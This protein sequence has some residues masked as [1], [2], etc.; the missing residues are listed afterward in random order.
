ML[1]INISYCVSL[2]GCGSS[3]VGT[4]LQNLGKFVYPTLPVSFGIGAIKGHSSVM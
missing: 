3:V 2:V 4:P 1:A